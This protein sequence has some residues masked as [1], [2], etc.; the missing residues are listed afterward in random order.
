MLQLLLDD[1]VHDCE[2]RVFTVLHSP[3]AVVLNVVAIPV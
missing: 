1:S 3:P 2:T